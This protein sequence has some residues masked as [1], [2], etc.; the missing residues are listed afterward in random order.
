[1]KYDIRATAASGA[2]LLVWLPANCC[3]A[4]LYGAPEQPVHLRRILRLYP[5]KDEAYWDWR[6]ITAPRLPGESLGSVFSA[7]GRQATGAQLPTIGA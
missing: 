5:T 7:G 1:M 3:L 2:L 6:R 4:L